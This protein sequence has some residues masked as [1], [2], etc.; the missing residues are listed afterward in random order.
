MF[1]PKRQENPPQLLAAQLVDARVAGQAEE[2]RLELRRRLQA[3]DRTDHFDE[4][5]LRQVL[6]V[7]AP[8]RHGVNEAC[9]PVLVG[10]DEF[11]LGVFVA[12]LGSAN[13]VGQRGR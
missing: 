5:L 1:F 4:D 7:I 6:D 13:E 8:I 12:L 10:N 2:P 11:T 9:D 3:V